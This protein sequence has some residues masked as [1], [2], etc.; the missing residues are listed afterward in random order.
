MKL[1]K[2]LVYRRA[3]KVE[4]QEDSNEN[5]RQFILSGRRIVKIQDFIKQIQELDNHSPCG[6]SF[7]DMLP[8]GEKRKG[9]NC[10]IIF[11][12]RMC[13]FSRIVWSEMCDDNKM[14]LNTSAVSG[15]VATGGGH[16]QLEEM[17]S[18]MDIPPMTDKTYKKYEIVVANGWMATAQDEMEKAAAEEAKLSVEHG[19]VD[20]DGTPLVTVVADGSWCKRSYRSNYSSLSGVVSSQRVYSS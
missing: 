2:W 15:T 20:K 6:C 5:K 13:N 1:C 12:C 16:A 4:E 18:T 14:D 7:K 9:L 10:G 8:V 19:E 17:L 3:N 11:K